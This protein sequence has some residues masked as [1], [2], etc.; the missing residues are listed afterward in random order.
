MGK[1]KDE[2][3]K[4]EKNDGNKH[5]KSDKKNHDKKNKLKGN[6]NGSKNYCESYYEYYENEKRPG[7]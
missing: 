2:E 4:D 6:E 3:S 1:L 5:E 7:N